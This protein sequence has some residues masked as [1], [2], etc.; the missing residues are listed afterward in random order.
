MSIRAR[1]VEFLCRL[2]LHSLEY[3]LCESGESYPVCRR[4]KVWWCWDGYRYTG[5]CWPPPFPGYPMLYRSWLLDRSNCVSEEEIDERLSR[6]FPYVFST[7]ER[8]G[9]SSKAK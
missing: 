5:E 1:F 6:C 2:G 4:C 9:N 3:I 8:N 7:K